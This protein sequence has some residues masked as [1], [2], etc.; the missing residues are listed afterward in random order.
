MKDQS[1]TI[2]PEG[3]I[4]Q[5]NGTNKGVQLRNRKGEIVFDSKLATTQAH[6]NRWQVVRYPDQE[7]YSVRNLDAGEERNV[8]GGVYL[9]HYVI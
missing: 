6:G 4:V 9:Q 1:T 3:E 2:A 8:D 5:Q 7:S